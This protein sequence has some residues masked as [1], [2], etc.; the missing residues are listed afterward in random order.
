MVQ[1]ISSATQ[2]YQTLQP[3]GLQHARPPCPSPTPGVYSNSCSLSQWCHSTISSSVV[4]FSFRLQSLPASGS[5]QM[6]QF[7]TSGGQ[8]IGA[9]ASASVLPM[10]IQDWFTLGWT[11][12]ILLAVRGSNNSSLK[13][14]VLVTTLPFRKY[15][16]FKIF[17]HFVYFIIVPVVDFCKYQWT[18]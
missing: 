7:F 6:S 4:P 16:A 2:S 13:L 14:L 18:I 9:S 12:L 1:I 10:N 17:C 11:G 8:S 15:V 3:H 5:F